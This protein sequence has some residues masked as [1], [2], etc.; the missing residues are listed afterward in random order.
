MQPGLTT[1]LYAPT[2]S[3]INPGLLKPL[4][5]I[6]SSVSSFLPSSTTADRLQIDVC[7]R[8]RD[9]GNAVDICFGLG[10]VDQGISTEPQLVTLGGSGS[11]STLS[12]FHVRRASH[13]ASSG[14]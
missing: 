1:E 4:D 12:F 14:T 8:L 5:Q 13:L 3:T 9:H 10:D 7:D 11:S 6:L 2:L